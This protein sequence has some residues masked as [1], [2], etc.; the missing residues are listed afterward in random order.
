MSCR[1]MFWNCGNLYMWRCSSRERVLVRLHC[2]F[3]LI[4]G[5]ILLRNRLLLLWL[6]IWFCSRAQTLCCIIRSWWLLTATCCRCNFSELILGVERCHIF[7]R[8]LLLQSS[9][10]QKSSHWWSWLRNL[11]TAF[12]WIFRY[13]FKFC[14][15][16]CYLSSSNRCHFCLFDLQL[17]KL[18]ISLNQLPLMLLLSLPNLIHHFNKLLALIRHLLHRLLHHAL[19]L[20]SSLFLLFLF[21]FSLLLLFP[22]S[23]LL[24]SF[25]SSHLIFHFFLAPF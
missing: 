17:I 16:R 8:W 14:R 12:L 22:P 18:L 20:E 10:F 11:G 4:I 13:R 24:F 1:V 3:Y 6:R 25:L 5:R 15:M 2:C 21:C 23:S 19:H 7:V 9:L